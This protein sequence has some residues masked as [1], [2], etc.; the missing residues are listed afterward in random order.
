MIYIVKPCG[1]VLGALN[2][3]KEE[4]CSL[5]CSLTDM[6]ELSFEIT[7]YIDDNNFAPS[8][9]YDSVAEK[10]RIRLETDL[11]D[12]MFVIDS[13]PVISN[14]GIQEIKK[15]TAHTIECELQN[16]I[17]RLFYI[18]NGNQTS[19]EYLANNNINQY[20]QLP[21]EYISLVNFDNHE[22]SLLHLVLEN[23][24]W[25][26]DE[27][28]KDTEQE[29]CAK[30]FSFSVDEIDIY[31][32]LMNEVA[33]VA[34][35][36]FFFDRKNRIISF[37]SYDNIG[38]DTGIFIGLRNLANQIDIESTSDTGLITKYK[39]TCSENL[40]VEYVNFGD[41]YL[42]NMNYF[43]NTHN[44]YGDFKFVTESFHN[45]YIAWTN[46]RNNN[47]QSYINF[48]KEYNSNLIKINELKNR[49]PNDG[50]NIDYKTY[51]ADELYLSLNAYEN[52]V[53]TLIALYKSEYPEKY[54]SP[55]IA[56]DETHLKSTMYWNDYYS[57]KYQ[58]IPSVKEAMKIW[59]E[60]DI[61]GNL[62][63][64]NDGKYILCENGNPSYASNVDIVKPIDSFK[65]EFTLYG[66]DEL[67]SK[68][69]AWMEC[70]NLLYK[71][72]FIKSGTVNDPTE[73]STP[74]ETGWNGLSAQQKLQFT[75]FNAFKEN[76]N[77]FL[78]YMSFNVRPNSITG[79]SC[80]G[81][82]RQCEDAIT[83][84]QNEINTLQSVNDV[85]QKDRNALSSSVLPENNFSVDN[86]KIF[87]LL[88][89]EDNYTNA[90]IVTTSLD[91]IVSIIDVAEELYQDAI[92]QLSIVSQPQYS[93]KTNIDNLFALEEFSSFRNKFKIGN[94]IKLLPDLFSDDFVKLRI[95]SIETNPFIE[96]NDFSV[97]FSTMTKS[98][99]DISDLAFLFGSNNGASG[100]SGG[101]NGSSGGTYG[102]NDAEIQIANN[103][104]NALLK[105]DTFGTQVSDI[106]L[107]SIK[108]NRANFGKLIAHSGI[109]DSLE[110]GDVKVKGAC[111]IDIIRS[112]NYVPGVEGS[113]FDL[114]D[115]SID[116]AGG[117][118]TYNKDK[119]LEIKGKKGKTSINGE[120]INT[121]AIVSNNYNGTTINPLGNTSG[122]ILDLFN[123]LF[124]F[125]GGKL[126][127]LDEQLYVKGDIIAETL[128]ANK[129]GTIAGWYFDNTGFYKLDQNNNKQMILGSNGI[130][131]GGTFSLD[132]NGQCNLNNVKS[133]YSNDI[134]SVNSNGVAIKNNNEYPVY[135]NS[136]NLGNIT[137]ED[138]TNVQIT[139]S[140]IYIGQFFRVSVV[141]TNHFSKGVYQNFFIDISGKVEKDGFFSPSDCVYIDASIQTIDNSSIDCTY[142]KSSQLLYIGIPSRFILNVYS[143]DN[144]THEREKPNT[145]YQVIGYLNDGSN[146]VPGEIK[147]V[148]IYKNCFVDETFT[149]TSLYKMY[150]LSINTEDNSIFSGLYKLTPKQFTSYTGF[151]FQHFDQ[152]N[153]NIPII[154][155][156][157]SHLIHK[158]LSTVSS[159]ND[160]IIK[161][162]NF[163]IKS[164]SSKRYK[165]NIQKINSNSEDKLD[166]H[167]LYDVDVVTF[168]YNNDYL[169]P[170]DQRYNTEIPGF[171]AEDIHEKYPIAC[172]LDK[173]GNPEMWDIH[174]MFPATL[175]LIQEQHEEI[176]QLK[177]RIE[178]LE[179]KI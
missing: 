6:W 51:K 122:T 111:L 54:T 66:L 141:C 168:K 112:M 10:M 131:A 123:G 116:Y 130:S 97:E 18:N 155:I 153:S 4:T 157:S 42:Y 124:N 73:Y 29:M 45:E 156:D 121:G 58:I 57:Y 89:H 2:S 25:T 80:K 84:R 146:Y 68:K 28:L 1:D 106:I 173:D 38:E 108:T 40:G 104:L 177:Q 8:D 92:N 136:I 12:T 24:E 3:I 167:K 142:D 56:L 65:Y 69:K 27:K 74:D 88:L 115:G 140:N 137:I 119:G 176:E 37:K 21:K 70:V 82:I 120:C 179:Q 13:E 32:F 79:T 169:H 26:I 125:G 160:V 60:T 100:S 75:T 148:E 50:C 41:P 17:L 154:Q 147:S 62:S 150:G 19:K 52:A 113:M 96:T 161:D 129:S 44:E 145:L 144:Q 101:N 174:V 36:I 109:F 143:I 59:Y 172:N 102:K 171:I 16:R 164:S 87:R 90:N 39:P 15:V 49:L 99:S 149:N 127:F 76:L 46:K 63:V 170:S 55:G 31:S 98:L 105:T 162:G 158:G 118:F 77:N 166:P 53:A 67:Q 14:N 159:G 94:F 5:K 175:K 133:L 43:A 85:I 9:Y 71:D 81:I 107:D 138:D 23:T 110:T 78:D 64:G 91:D 33:K 151:S 22:L 134:F 128:T 7:K 163:C 126:K 132:S 20:T 72:G 139:F 30:K 135:S 114:K 35:I 165:H 48:T 178:I 152:L 11:V 34:Q 103:M 47:R 95:I 117:S 86:L 61:Y 93:F 83:E